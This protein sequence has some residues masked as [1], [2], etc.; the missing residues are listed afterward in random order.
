M[1]LFNIYILPTSK[2]IIMSNKD[3]KKSLNGKDTADLNDIPKI[4]FDPDSVIAVREGK[5]NSYGL[6]LTHPEDIGFEYGNINFAIVNGIKD[7]VRSSLKVQLRVEKKRNRSSAE[8]FHKP[9][10]NLLDEGALEYTAKSIAERIKVETPKVRAAL[11]E[12]RENLDKYRNDLLYAPK[13]EESSKAI[14]NASAKEV[15]AFLKQDGLL[16]KLAEQLEVAGVVDGV[17]GL[18]LLILGLSRMTGNPIHGILQGSLLHSSELFKQMVEVIPQ[19][20]LREVTSISNTALSYP[21]YQNYWQHKTLLIH[22]LDGALKKDSLLLEYINQGQLKRIV[23]EVDYRNGTR[24]SGEKTNQDV[25]GVMGY[26][27]KDYLPIFNASNVVCLP[28]KS[29]KAFK[30]KLYDREI[31]EFAGLLDND[32]TKTSQELLINIQRFLKP[33]KVVN[34]YLD[35]IDFQSF[36]GND[37]KQVRLFLQITNLITLLHQAGLNPKKKDGVEYLEVKAEHMIA[38]MELFKDVWLSKDEELYFKVL[39]TFEA[40]KRVLKKEHPESYKEVVFKKADIR[41]KTGVAFSTFGKHINQLDA[42]GKL[43]RVG[44]S[45]REGYDF[46]VLEWEESNDNVKKFNQLINQLKNE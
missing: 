43:Q 30:D 28:L 3:T 21:K 23:T 44:G 32:Q 11:L 29:T 10:I 39:G 33:H 36:F 38:A 26:T 16:D 40:I 17:M 31:K 42:Y 45:R 13:K 9:V 18:K 6:D 14:S 37:I 24:R 2:S 19:E 22:Q 15:K 5:V 4:I 34:T 25:F 46:K 7:F 35:H 27:V 20:Q 12:L 1:E 8:I 41:I